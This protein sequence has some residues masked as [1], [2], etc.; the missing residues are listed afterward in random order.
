MNRIIL[1]ACSI[2]LAA[3]VTADVV[4][5]EIHYDPEDKVQS[6]EFIELFNS[7]PDSVDVSGWGFTTGVG[8]VFPDGTTIAS[9]GYLV[10]AESPEQITE[11]FGAQALGP[12]EGG[13]RNSGETVTL[14]R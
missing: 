1:F 4:I 10:V 3:P 13:L 14:L 5:N 12:W 7:G 9:D 6:L 11:V 8:F 2:I